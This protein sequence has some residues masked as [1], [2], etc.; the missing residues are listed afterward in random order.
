[1]L[2]RIRA[3]RL[4]IN[5]AWVDSSRVRGLP[6]SE[7]GILGPEDA[8]RPPADQFT[9][10]SRRMKDTVSSGAGSEAEA[11]RPTD[12]VGRTDALR[13]QRRAG[14]DQAP[15]LPFFKVGKAQIPHSG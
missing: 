9:L 11:P 15:L 1:M 3:E 10:M 4:A 7:R 2:D 12:P 5:G 13:L 8:E 6:A 14:A